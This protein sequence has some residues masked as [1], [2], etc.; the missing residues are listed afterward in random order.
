MNLG[1]DQRTAVVLAST[2]GLGRAVAEA[3]LTE[4]AT[5]A[6]SGRNADRVEETLAALRNAHGDRVLGSALDVTDRAALSAH[7]EEVCE[8]TGSVDILVTNAGGPP[9]GGS[10][11]VTHDGLDAAW[12]LTMHSAV[13]AVQ[14]VLP[15]MRA[16]KWGRIL[17][18]TSLTVRHPN[19]SL[20]YSN[21]VRA[22]LTAYFKT[23]ADEVGGDGVIVNTVCTGMFGT[24]RLDEL[25]E[26]RARASGTTVEDQRSAA[27]ASIPVG[28]I[29]DPAE[30]GAFCAFLVS[31]RNTFV[32][33]SNL[34][35]DGGAGRFL[36]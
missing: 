21:I 30:F 34:P 1:I 14:V 36:L 2:G 17:A 31:A 7:L 27:V 13:H 24:E 32:H 26:A 5:V 11:A 35:I 6:V 15:W 19:P 28:R 3:L 22:G 16:K 20:A 29:G 25:F 12:E 23:L 4:G 18:M 33:G 8:R 9:P 10:V